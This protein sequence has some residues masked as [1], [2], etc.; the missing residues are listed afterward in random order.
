MVFVLVSSSVV[1]EAAVLVSPWLVSLAAS[2]DMIFLRKMNELDV[3]QKRPKKHH[4][5]SIIH[6]HHDHHTY[7]HC[8]KPAQ[9]SIINSCTSSQHQFSSCCAFVHN[10]HS[11]PL[12]ILVPHLKI[13]VSSLDP[14]GKILLVVIIRNIHFHI[15]IAGMFLNQRCFKI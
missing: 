9:Q 5:Q 12:C 7:N 14:I 1:V 13:A 6:H 8:P 4:P 3:I 11:L 2:A 15:Q 10:H